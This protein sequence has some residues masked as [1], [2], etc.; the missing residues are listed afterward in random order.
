M[1]RRFAFTSVLVIAAMLL[2]AVPAAAENGDGGVDVLID[3]NSFF[4]NGTEDPLARLHEAWVLPCGADPEAEDSWYYYYE[5]P[6]PDETWTSMADYTE[7]EFTANIAAIEYSWHYGEAGGD[8]Y[9]GYVEGSCEVAAEP[10]VVT[11][12]WGYV[13]PA[14]D[15]NIC[16]IL[17][18]TSPTQS[19]EDNDVRRLCFKESSPDWWNGATLL[20]HGD[21]YEN[22][23]P[24]GRWEGDA[25]ANA[26]NPNAKR[27]PLHAP[28]G[29]KDLLDIV[30]MAP[31][32][33]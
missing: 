1:K 29:E 20:T 21:V 30:E 19:E 7:G 12:L 10:P 14:A 27:L 8:D 24:F 17:S 22:G 31:W 32:T 6:H 26:F 2:A 25:A 16:Y 28:A 4:P 13:N 15:R 5:Y 11:G 33:Q 9:W 23:F 3:G 18:L